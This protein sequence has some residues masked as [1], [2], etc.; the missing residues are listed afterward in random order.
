MQC[1]IG[2]KRGGVRVRIVNID[3]LDAFGDTLSDLFVSRF[4]MQ[5]QGNG[6]GH[7]LDARR[8]VSFQNSPLHDRTICEKGEW[9]VL[10]V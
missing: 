9:T 2:K 5:I 3:L 7:P 8:N 4:S 10:Q 1:L 6:L